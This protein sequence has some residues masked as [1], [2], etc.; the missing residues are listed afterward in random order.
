MRVCDACRSGD[1]IR[2][3]KLHLTSDTTSPVNWNGELCPNC[4][5]RLVRSVRET[6]LGVLNT[7][8]AAR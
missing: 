7:P 6:I 4:L 3:V 8:K 2:P 1:S 5:D